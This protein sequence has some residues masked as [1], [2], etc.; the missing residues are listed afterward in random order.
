MRGRDITGHLGKPS[1]W[2]YKAAHEANLRESKLVAEVQKPYAKERI[3]SGDAY[4][5][6]LAVQLTD[7][8]RT[9]LEEDLASEIASFCPDAQAPRILTVDDVARIASHFP[10]FLHDYHGLEFQSRTLTFPAWGKSITARTPTFVPTPAFEVLKQRVEGFTDPVTIPYRPLLV[11]H[12]KA[13]VGK[14][15]SVY[16]ALKPVKASAATA[17]YAGDAKQALEFAHILANNEEMSAILVIDDISLESRHR[18][19]EL[20]EGHK[21]RVRTIVIQHD[22]EPEDSK[23]E[24]LYTVRVD[25]EVIDGILLANFKQIPIS[26][27]TAYVSLSLSLSLSL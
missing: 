16:E 10:N 6:C 13:A 19:S 11:V 1:I 12:G 25:Q 18:L 23:L 2:Q 22:S 17:V 5:L 26:R 7:E 15:R 9:Q 8:K 27:L 20:L 14:T 4:R 3:R 24:N 21:H